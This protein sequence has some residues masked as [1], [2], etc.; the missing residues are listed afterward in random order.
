MSDARLALS[1]VRKTFEQAGRKLEI[2]RGISFAL[3]KAEMV[4]LVGPSGAGIAA[5]QPW[6]GR[7]EGRARPGWK[8]P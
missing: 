8:G 7:R 5:G 1:E 6:A 2:L 3:E 4:A